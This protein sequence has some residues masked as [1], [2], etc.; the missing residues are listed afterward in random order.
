MRPNLYG[1]YQVDTVILQHDTVI[2]LAE[3]I[4]CMYKLII[5]LTVNVFPHV[6]HAVSSY[7]IDTVQEHLQT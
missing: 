5:L 7:R 6:A 3:I 1:V 2:I 4:T